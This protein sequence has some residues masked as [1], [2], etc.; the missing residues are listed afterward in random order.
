MNWYDRDKNWFNRHLWWTWAIGNFVV[1]FVAYLPVLLTS[2]DN[3]PWVMVWWVLV[4]V[5][6][7]IALMLYVETV[8]LR[9]KGR[10]LWFLLLTLMLFL[11][12]AI[13]MQLESRVETEE[14][15]EAKG[16]NK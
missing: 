11:G 3:P 8:A 9:Q 2:S 5:T 7:I 13:I 16:E 10:S 12:M 4:L 6:G 15:V 14:E 1:V